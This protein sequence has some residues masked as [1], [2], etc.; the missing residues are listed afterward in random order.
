MSEV[1]RGRSNA[2]VLSMETSSN[3]S[4]EKTTGQGRGRAWTWECPGR[5]HFGRC[6]MWR[7]IG[8]HRKTMTGRS[9]TGAI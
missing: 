3:G 7:I 2:P 1:V 8:L 9:S 5:Q 6:V 4:L